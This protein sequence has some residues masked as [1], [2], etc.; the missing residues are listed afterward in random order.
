MNEA[1]LVWLGEEIVGELRTSGRR[2]AQLHPAGPRIGLAAGVPDDGSPWPADFTR[3]WFE[4]LLPEEEPRT[5]IAARFGL[6]P[7]DTWGLLERIGWECA[8]AVAVLPSGRTPHS[9]SY[10]ELSEPEIW[11]RLDE[12]PGRPY[13]RDAALRMSL[14]GSQSK[15]LLA[16]RDDRWH[17]PLDGAPSTHILKPEPVY[18]PGLAVAEAWALRVASSATLAADT[19]VMIA[20]GH[21]P[22]LVVTR[23]DREAVGDGVRR[24]HQEDMCQVLGILPDIKYAE[25]PE[26]DRQPSYLRLAAVL[27]RGALD[28]TAELVRLLEHVTINVAIGN[29]DAHG[30]NTSIFHVSGGLQLTPM[31]DV[32]PTLAFIRQRHS[33]MSVAARFVITEITREHLVREAHSW[34]MPERVAR[35]TVDRVLDAIRKLGVPAADDLH[36]TLRPD[37][38]AS[39]LEQIARVAAS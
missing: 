12:L 11:Q 35:A 19:K 10:Q 32:A 31:Y 25:H 33:G 29:T 27:E 1:L 6:R 16:R 17:Q 39:A 38:R 15:L 21:A 24:I 2:S 7:E 37:V 26:N 8:G 20:E 18:H 22:T 13:E 23:F 34:G 9:G 4:N 5:R 36:P 28:P 14:G 3:A 30:K